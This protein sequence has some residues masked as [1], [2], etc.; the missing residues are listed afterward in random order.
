LDVGECFKVRSFETRGSSLREGEVGKVFDLYFGVL[1]K[2]VEG[3]A[4]EW[5]YSQVPRR[6]SVAFHGRRRL[7]FFSVIE[8]HSWVAL[9]AWTSVLLL[10]EP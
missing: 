4:V 8:Y 6:P 2:L 9:W 1:Q 7:V 5:L 3:A 10:V